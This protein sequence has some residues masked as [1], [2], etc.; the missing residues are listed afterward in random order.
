MRKLILTIPLLG[1]L[2][3]CGVSI[4]NQIILTS[5]AMACYSAI[6]AATSAS[7]TVQNVLTG[8]QVLAS[9]PACTALNAAAA[10]LVA[11]ALNGGITPTLGVS[12][13]INTGL[14]ARVM[15]T[16]N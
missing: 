1:A 6:Q 4:P 5:D 3:G 16:G 10:E 14:V 2:A 12:S 13:R 8:A 7:N 9:N 11:S 15:K